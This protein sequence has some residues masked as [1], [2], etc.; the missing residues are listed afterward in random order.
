MKIIDKPITVVT[1]K[2]KIPQS[3][4]YRGTQQ[5][6]KI[7]DFWLEAGEWWEGQPER[8]VYRVRTKGGGM[9]E[10]Y[11]NKGEQAWFLYKVYD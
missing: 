10:L 4:T 11:R 9:F 8:A 2:L 5:V 6:E 3:F 1:R 7:L